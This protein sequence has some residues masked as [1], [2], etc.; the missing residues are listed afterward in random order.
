MNMQVRWGSTR[1]VLLIGR[2]AV[3]TPSRVEW[4]LFLHGLLANLQERLWSQT[5]D[6]RLARVLW[7]DPF[8]LVLVMERADPLPRN[9]HPKHFAAIME[10]QR[11]EGLPQDIKMD[12]FGF[13]GRSM[14]MI[15]YGS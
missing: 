6:Q 13:R 12:N 2:W 1:T 4:R 9:L 10:L 8:G 3:K 5:G 14:V 15:D 11:F 7:A